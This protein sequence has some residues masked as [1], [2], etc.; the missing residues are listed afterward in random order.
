MSTS[1]LVEDRGAVRV[2]TLNRPERRNALDLDDRLALA[3]ALVAADREARAIVLTGTAPT[4]C[5]GGDIASMTPDPV[6]GRR[7]LDAVAAIARAMATSSTPIV[8]AVEGGAFGL[9]LALACHSD[10]VVASRSSRFAASFARIGLAPDTGLFWSLPRRVGPALT[11]RM[12]L[13]ACTVDAD[14]ALTAGLVDEL[15]EDGTT[16]ERAMALAEELAA[17]S[18]PV[19]AGVRRTLAQPDQTLEGL[20]EAEAELQL[21]LF[22]SPE[23]AEGRAAFFERRPANFADPAGVDSQ[24]RRPGAP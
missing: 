5:S 8:T 24:A 22:G 7:R 1:V 20:L 23:F 19:V 2:L 9:G 17:V 14:E 15:V 3:E 10:L 18:A 6:V 12:V 13:T 21:E 16:L 11:R 4:F